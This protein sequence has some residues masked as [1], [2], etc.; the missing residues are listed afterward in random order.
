MYNFFNVDNNKLRHVNPDVVMAVINDI[1][2]HFGDLTIS[3]DSKHDY[4]GMDVELKDG[5]FYFGI[6]GQMKEVLE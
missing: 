3:R 4:L 1:S 6:N 5:K 2:E